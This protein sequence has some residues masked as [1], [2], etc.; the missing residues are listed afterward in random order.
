[1]PKRVLSAASTAAR[2]RLRATLTALC[3]CALLAL[4]A[5]CGDDG[6]GAHD[7]SRGFARSYAPA[8]TPMMSREWEAL[9]LDGRGVRIGVIDAGFRD[10]RTDPWL[11]GLRVE[12]QRDFTGSIADHD[13]SADKSGHGTRVLRRLAGQRE[14]RVDGLATGARYLLAKA[15]RPRG[16]PR[17]D[18]DG[19]IAALRWLAAER[20]DVIN[21]SLGFSTFDDFTGYRPAQLTGTGSRISAALTALLAAN[22]DLVVVV[23]AGNLGDDDWRYLSFPADVAEALTVGSIDP[24]T[25]GRTDSSSLGWPATPWIKPDLATHETRG[26]SYS[27]PS[28]AGLV[29]CLRQHAPELQRRELLTLLRRSGTRAARPDREVGYGI[30]RS[31]ELLRLLAQRTT[32]V[33]TPPAAAVSPAQPAAPAA[34]PPSR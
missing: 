2:A 34:A 5:G 29:A 4:P 9:G 8:L 28:V 10:F 21:L 17:S 30:P 13:L 7:Y 11:Q 19:V 22:P 24:E 33:A 20:V 12:A 25:G 27:A 23:S 1:M 6:Y 14:G 16:E 3:L 18:E 26:N 32:P 31:A 15:E